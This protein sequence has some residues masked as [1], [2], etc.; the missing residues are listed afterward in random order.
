MT[1]L[2]AL[3]KLIIIT[4][5]IIVLGALIACKPIRTEP[6]EIKPI[7]DYI[8]LDLPAKRDRA[9]IIDEDGFMRRMYYYNDPVDYDEWFYYQGKSIIGELY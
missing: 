6:F 2:T 5:I 9:F 1:E 8:H 4:L 3:G 7:D